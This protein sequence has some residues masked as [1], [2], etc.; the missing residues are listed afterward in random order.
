MPTP[1]NRLRKVSDGSFG[2]P[3]PTRPATYDEVMNSLSGKVHRW[4]FDE[5]TGYPQ[6]SVGTLHMSAGTVT[7]RGMA[8]PLGMA[9]QLNG[10]NG[11]GNGNAPMGNN[12]R[13]FVGVWKSETYTN[14]ARDILNYGPT[15]STRQWNSV[16]ANHDAIYQGPNVLFW[17][18][19]HK[20]G[21]FFADAQWHW[22]AVLYGGRAVNIWLD[23]YLSY[24]GTTGAN[25]NTTNS[26]NLSFGLGV[27][28]DLTIF[29]RWVARVELQR[30]W[31][32][33]KD[34]Y[35]FGAP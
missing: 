17:S 13:T 23:G 30:L 10:T 31:D 16:C 6:D 4:K 3:A 26:G 11:T 1:T 35:G 21:G 9:M 18:D 12:E 15:G 5:S 29:S 22:F 25:L 34:G 8:S 7:T 14:G 27:Y 19:D 33:I 28:D 2:A 20:P 32:T 24:Y